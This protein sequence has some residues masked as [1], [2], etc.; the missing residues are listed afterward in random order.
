VT[1]CEEVR[2]ITCGMWGSGYFTEHVAVKWW[3]GYHF[4][5]EI[6]WGFM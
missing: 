5:L 2:A 6:Y 1:A 3:N 4:F